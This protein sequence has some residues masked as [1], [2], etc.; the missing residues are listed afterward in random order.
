MFRFRTQLF[1]Y[2]PGQRST[3]TERCSLHIFSLKRGKVLTVLYREF[4]MHS[5]VFAVARFLLLSNM[6]STLHDL[7]PPLSCDEDDATVW[8]FV[9]MF[10]SCVCLG[11]ALRTTED[12][13]MICSR[14]PEPLA[15]LIQ[16]MSDFFP[17]PSH[18]K[19][20][21]HPTVH[22]LSKLLH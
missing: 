1:S 5:H 7:I 12:W 17:P 8:S 18:M 22:L 21:Q 13:C 16:S 10:M 11:F 9:V 14:P 6:A 20:S 19:N 15:D 4:H 2:T 3:K